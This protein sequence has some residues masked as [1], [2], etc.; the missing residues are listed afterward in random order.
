[1]GGDT[2][3]YHGRNNFS[4]Q[5]SVVSRLYISSQHTLLT[6]MKLITTHSDKL[7]LVLFMI[8]GMVSTKINLTLKDRKLV[9]A[10]LRGSPFNTW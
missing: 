3:W 8:G 6:L 10:I 1:M 4:L 7:R 5:M 2:V 9:Q